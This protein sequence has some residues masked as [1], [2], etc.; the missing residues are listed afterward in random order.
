MNRKIILTAA[1]MA[2]I[3]I[4]PALGYYGGSNMG[5]YPSFSGYIYSY[6]SAEEVGRYV[7]DAKE[8]IEKC[9]NDIEEIIRKRDEAARDANDAI[10]RYKSSRY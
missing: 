1:F 8:Y 3:G 7:D 5:Y 2:F 4:S 10:Y 6:S 9:N